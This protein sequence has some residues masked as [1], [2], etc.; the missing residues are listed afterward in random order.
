MWQRP[1]A[2]AL[3]TRLKRPVSGPRPQSR[4]VGGP[5]VRISTITSCTWATPVYASTRQSSLSFGTWRSSKTGRRA[6]ASFT[7]RCAASE[8]LAGQIHARRRASLRPHEKAAWPWPDRPSVPDDPEG[9]FQY[10]PGRA[11]LQEEPR[12]QLSHNL[13]P[14]AHLHLDAPSRRR[15][16]LPDRQKNFRTGV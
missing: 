15:G 13:Q 7:L 14:A 8:A 9:A 10:H 5:P 1:A 12:G 16:H 11:G 4:S 3:P 6:S 2:A